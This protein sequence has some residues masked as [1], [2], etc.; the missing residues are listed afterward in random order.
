MYEN[1]TD[2]LRSNLKLNEISTLLFSQFYKI[3]RNQ[4][5]IVV[6]AI[7]GLHPNKYFKILNLTFWGR[8]LVKRSFGVHSNSR[9]VGEIKDLPI[10]INFS[11]RNMESCYSC[12]AFYLHACSKTY[13]VFWLSNTHASVCVTVRSPK[14]NMVWI[15]YLLC[16]SV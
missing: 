7:Y 15:I 13:Q 12:F 8:T 2:H 10:S 3:I 6:K 4:L 1:Y 14:K 5:E 16:Q 11:N 9:G